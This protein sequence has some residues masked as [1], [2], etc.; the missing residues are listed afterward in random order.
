MHPQ[1]KTRGPTKRTGRKTKRR[2][3][4]FWS[5]AAALIDVLMSEFGRTEEE[6]ARAVAEQLRKRGLLFC[7]PRACSPDWKLLQTWRDKIRNGEKGDSREWYDEA[8][9]WASSYESE[10]DLYDDF[11][12]PK[13]LPLEPLGLDTA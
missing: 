11:L 9:S 6:A 5:H 12:N 1:R 2:K 10:A 8:L 7:S 3:K 13:L 4:F